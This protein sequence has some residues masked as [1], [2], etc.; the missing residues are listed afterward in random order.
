MQLGSN[1]VAV[2]QYPY[3]S[4]H[5]KILLATRSFYWAHQWPK[6]CVWK[7]CR[8]STTKFYRF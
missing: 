6:F 2:V 5:N 8:W 7:Y 4:T 1:P 3:T